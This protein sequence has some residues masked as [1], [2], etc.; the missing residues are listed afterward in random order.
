MLLLRGMLE[1]A[2]LQSGLPKMKK[3]NADGWWNTMKENE[4]EKLKERSLVTKNFSR[5]WL[6]ILHHFPNT[7]KALSPIPISDVKN[8][9]DHCTFLLVIE[10][11]F[12]VISSHVISRHPYC[13]IAKVVN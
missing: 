7:H 9:K 3:Q 11:F 8:V 4:I 2:V 6:K 5:K 13:F 10:E 1:K 12:C